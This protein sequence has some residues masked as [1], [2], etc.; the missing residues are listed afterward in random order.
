MAFF[1]AKRFFVIMLALVFVG[2]C[3]GSQIA[4]GGDDDGPEWY[5]NPPKGCG[6]ASSKHRG[7]RELT[8]KAAT[9]SARANLAAS[10]KTIVQ[11]MLK[12]Y[13]RAGQVDDKDFNEEDQR[14]A[15]R[16][17]VDQTM[18]GTRVVKT[19]MRAGE[20][21][22]LVCLDPETFG[23][24]FERMNKLNQAQRQ[25]LKARAETEFKELD[26][27]VQTLKGR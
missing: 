27:Q 12:R 17:V 19:K 10:L 24:A 2:A 21:F 23:D 25:A 11:D 13:M 22:A 18:V 26:R 4:A 15:T 6:T 9:Q 20:M 16:T 3:G 14:S 7:I 1:S 5:D 8:R